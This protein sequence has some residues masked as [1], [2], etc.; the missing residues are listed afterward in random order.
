MGQ[1]TNLRFYGAPRSS[2]FISIGPSCQN[3]G[4][5]SLRHLNSLNESLVAFRA[6]NLA[7]CQ[8]LTIEFIDAACTGIS[9]QEL[10]PGKLE[11]VDAACC[12]YRRFVPGTS[13][14]SNAVFLLFYGPA[15]GSVFSE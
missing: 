11:F 4:A 3:H 1:L 15:F 8:Y 12:V 5:A 7:S 14:L 2:C 13:P 6:R 9:C 10:V